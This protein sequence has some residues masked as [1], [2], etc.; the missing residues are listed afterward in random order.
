MLDLNVQMPL[1]FLIKKTLSNSIQTKL[2]LN[3]SLKPV[4]VVLTLHLPVLNSHQPHQRERT[5]NYEVNK[6]FSN[7]VSK[8]LVL[9]HE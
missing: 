6:M 7:T 3:A 5:T 1:V 8:R 2:F 4:D 9:F